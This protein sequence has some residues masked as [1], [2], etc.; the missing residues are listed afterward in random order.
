[1]ENAI[2]IEIAEM[3]AASIPANKKAAVTQPELEFR[4]KHDQGTGGVCYGT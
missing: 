3:I 1:M 2:S 4:K